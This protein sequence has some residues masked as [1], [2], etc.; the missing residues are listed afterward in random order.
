MMNKFTNTLK[1]L[2]MIYKTFFTC[3]MQS[4]D[5]VAYVSLRMVHASR[6]VMSLAINNI[7]VTNREP[8]IALRI[9]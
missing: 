1:T 2:S 6:E 7:I 8:M 3:S 5:G 9:N 4:R